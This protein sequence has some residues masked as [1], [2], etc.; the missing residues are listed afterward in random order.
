MKFSSGPI[1]PAMARR[2]PKS[3]LHATA[4]HYEGRE[5]GITRLL[6]PE[7]AVKIPLREHTAFWRGKGIV[8]SNPSDLRDHYKQGQTNYKTSTRRQNVKYSRLIWI[9]LDQDGALIKEEV[10][11]H[12]RGTA[13]MG[14]VGD[15][16]FRFVQGV[17]SMPG[18]ECTSKPR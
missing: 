10:Y 2:D 12:A 4:V 15:G 3:K 13:G 9:V 17:A 14:G 7:P 18:P 16:F 1:A 6:R 8:M 11:W 5:G